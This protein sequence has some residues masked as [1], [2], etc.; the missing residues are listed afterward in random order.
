MILEKNWLKKKFKRAFFRNYQM[1]YL[2]E[3]DLYIDFVLIVN[4][5]CTKIDIRR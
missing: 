1:N 4:M 5:F 2:I 3:F